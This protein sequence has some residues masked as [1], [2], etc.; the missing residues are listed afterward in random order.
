MPAAPKQT[1]GYIALQLKAQKVA[2][3]QAAQREKEQFSR[4]AEQQDKALNVK[5]IDSA[6]KNYNEGE[7]RKLQLAGLMGRSAESNEVRRAIAEMGDRTKRDI[8]TGKNEDRD[9]ERNRK[10]D[11]DAAKLT[12]DMAKQEEKKLEFGKTLEQKDR[13][14]TED[15]MTKLSGQQDQW[16]GT[17]RNQVLERDEKGQPT[18]LGG[19]AAPT[20]GGTNVG[21]EGRKKAVKDLDDIEQELADSDESIKLVKE[22]NKEFFNPIAGGTDLT[23]PKNKFTNFFGVADKSVHVGGNSWKNLVANFDNLSPEKKAEV[24]KYRAAEQSIGRLLQTYRHRMTGAQFTDKESAGYNK[25]L[26]GLNA[27]E[28][29]SNDQALLVDALTN[30]R[31]HAAKRVKLLRQIANT[32]I[33]PDYNL[34][35][36]EIEHQIGAPVNESPPAPAS[37]N[38]DTPVA[39]PA[40]GGLIQSII[41][42]TSQG[43]EGPPASAPAAKDGPTLA[44]LL[45]QPQNGNLRA[46]GQ[47]NPQVQRSL[48]EFFRSLPPDLSQRQKTQMGYQHLRELFQQSQPKQPTNDIPF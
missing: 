38:P 13:Q 42:G 33:R 23:V 10:L 44:D 17:P 27:E 1:L 39:P 35:N 16:S 48:Q 47:S 24:S 9:A 11:T 3:D 37:G 41:G 15:N 43:S 45:N 8:E 6:F 22:T 46:F 14:H 30:T 5:S 36:D 2:A 34:T 20:E 21:K 29:F 40:G 31:N 26:T 4:E 19:T 32:G 25:T 7:N 28:P 18:K 12:E